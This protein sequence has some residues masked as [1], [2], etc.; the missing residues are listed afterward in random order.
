VNSLFK[1]K[2]YHADHN[3]EDSPIAIILGCAGMV[4]SCTEQCMLGNVRGGFCFSS[5][6]MQLEK[7]SLHPVTAWWGSIAASAGLRLPVTM[8]G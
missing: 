5:T 2:P 7:R 8:I 1:S 3:L 6:K 4:L